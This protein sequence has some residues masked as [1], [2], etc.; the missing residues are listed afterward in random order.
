MLISTELNSKD[1]TVDAREAGKYALTRVKFENRWGFRQ[2]FV[3]DFFV[4]SSHQRPKDQLS[5]W[6]IDQFHLGVPL[7][8]PTANVVHWRSAAVAPSCFS[9]L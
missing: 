4:A 2:G 6:F 8:W 7:W 9:L 5:L 1:H 3:Q